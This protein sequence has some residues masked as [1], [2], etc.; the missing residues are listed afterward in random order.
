MWALVVNNANSVTALKFVL[1]CYAVTSQI[2]VFA[3]YH[4]SL[5]IFSILY[6]LIVT[7]AAVVLTS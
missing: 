2:N 7:A 4:V 1:F 5:Q 6:M 3:D